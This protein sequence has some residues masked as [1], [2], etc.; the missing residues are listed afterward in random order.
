[1]WLIWL[2]IALLAALAEVASLNFVLLM[3][4]GGALAAA[5]AD[6]LGASLPV[7][8][9]VFSIV[10]TALLLVGRPPLVRWSERSAG[11]LTGV[12]ALV[13]QTAEVL[14]EVDP[15]GGQVKLAGE[16]WSARA[17]GPA[18]VLPLGTRVTVLRIDGA[19]AVVA[20]EPPQLGTVAQEPDAPAT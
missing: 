7:E 13:G 1:M 15:R 18:I 20:A 17:E 4:A 8:V 9:V 10:S 12:D 6:A 11:H 5:L 3:F 14:A 16:V 19:T 2:A